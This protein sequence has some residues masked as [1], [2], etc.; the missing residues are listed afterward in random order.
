MS[1]LQDLLTA[2]AALQDAVDAHDEAGP[3]GSSV[4]PEI[5]DRR[6][7]V[8]A[9]ARAYVREREDLIAAELTAEV[10]ERL[11]QVATERDELFVKLTAATERL[12]IAERRE[13]IAADAH[14]R[15]VDAL[16]TRVTRLEAR[17]ASADQRAARL[18]VERDAALARVAELEDA[19]D[20]AAE[21]A[22]GDVGDLVLADEIGRQETADAP[23][24]EREEDR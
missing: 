20:L 24:D 8:I 6:L 9:A 18:A 22:S 14:R 21:A 19:Q 11:G 4:L 23:A 1:A 17:L 2:A 16:R 3:N 7:A 15:D 10:R 5:A 12:R 13:E